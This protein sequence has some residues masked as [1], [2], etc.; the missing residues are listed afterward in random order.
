MRGA[1]GK[2]RDLA[3]VRTTPLCLL[4]CQRPL[5]W[6]LALILAPPLTHSLNYN[7]IGVE[8]ASAL[9]AILKETKITTLGCAAALARVFLSCQHPIDTKA[10]TFAF[11]SVSESEHV[12]F[13]PWTN[14]R[15]RRAS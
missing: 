10:H 7:N 6:L 14:W 15:R 2:R 9:A 13:S 5:T 8:S 11:P 3:Q 12:P 1:Q 4:S